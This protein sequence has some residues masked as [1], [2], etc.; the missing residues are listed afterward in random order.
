MPADGTALATCGACARAA[1]AAGISGFCDSVFC[2][3][4]F[5]V[6]T[7]AVS[8]LRGA[9]AVGFRP[10]RV[11]VCGAGCGAGSVFGLNSRAKKPSLL[12][13]LLAEAAWLVLWLG[14]WL[15][16]WVVGRANKPPNRPRFWNSAGFLLP[17]GAFTGPLVC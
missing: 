4:D 5:A 16:V 9:G 14:F 2:G 17:L 10:A 3:S 7:F 8:T 13:L 12:E 6:S 1:A 11:V 15:V